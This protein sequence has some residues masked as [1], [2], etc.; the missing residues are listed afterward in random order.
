M[1]KRDDYIRN[2]RD[3]AT[4]LLLAGGQDY[5]LGSVHGTKAA[6]DD[7]VIV[8]W[9]VGLSPRHL[10]IW[11]AGKKVLN[12][13]THRNDTDGE[14]MVVVSFKRGEWESKL[15]HAGAVATLTS[16]RLVAAKSPSSMIH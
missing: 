5:L 15:L 11:A 3:A 12:I 10:D 4:T 7:I 16:D 14:Q 6:T 8:G 1:T 13:E 2:L 9:S